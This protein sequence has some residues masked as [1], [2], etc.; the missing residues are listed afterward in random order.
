MSNHIDD[1]THLGDDDMAFEALRELEQ[2]TPDEIKMRRASSRV[3]IKSKVILQP[4]NSSDALKLKLR[5][6]TGNISNTG[7]GAVF[8]IP[9]GAGDI[10]RLQ[11]DS[12]QVDLPMVF[13]RCM[14]C[15]MVDENAFSAGFKFFTEIDV[16]RV[17]KQAAQ[18]SM[19][20]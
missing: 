11:F 4:G 6:V 8:P 9:I 1:G 3:T 20:V 12:T 15:S 19:L 17:V 16:S 5:G 18:E 14:S 2:Q 13:A 7:F 10:Y